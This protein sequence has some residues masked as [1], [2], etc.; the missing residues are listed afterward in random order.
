MI[1]SGDK[2]EPWCM[3][4]ME[5]RVFVPELVQADNKENVKAVYYLCDNEWPS[6]SARYRESVSILRGH[7]GYITL[8]WR[9]NESVSVLNHRRLNCLLNR[10]FMRRSKKTSKLHTVLCER[11]P[12]VTGGFPSQRSSNPEKCFHLMTSSW[13]ANC[14]RVAR[15]VWIVSILYSP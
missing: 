9:Y 5:S 8:Q 7:H 6:Q 15:H 3:K 10:L 2:S 12:S 1:D 11:N 14:C 4:S 13:K